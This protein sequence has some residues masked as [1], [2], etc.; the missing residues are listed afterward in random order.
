[1]EFPQEV[2]G[3]ATENRISKAVYQLN[4][5]VL[6]IT[7]AAPRKTEGK[8]DFYMRRYVLATF[9][10]I[11]ALTACRNMLPEPTPT[12]SPQVAKGKHVFDTYCSRCH[13]TSGNTVVVGPSLAGIATRG[14]SRVSGQDAQTYIQNS[15]QNP[16][17]YT[18][19]GFVEGT[20][21]PNFS[22]VLSQEE[23]QAVVA[24]LLTL[25]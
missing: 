17:A 15:I 19:D 21:P 10:M 7:R 8:H 20:M 1:L 9:L 25:E 16:T 4:T 6:P 24:F 11:A 2:V 3:Q 14:S 22:E 23:F 13:G 18:V 12:P 5:W